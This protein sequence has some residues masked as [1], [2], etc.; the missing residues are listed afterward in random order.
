M[1]R[2]LEAFGEIDE[3]YWTSAMSCERRPIKRWGLRKD[4]MV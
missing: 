3:R 2:I 4:M 1:Q